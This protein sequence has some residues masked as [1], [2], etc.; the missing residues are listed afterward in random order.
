M[1]L[2]TLD[3][4]LARLSILLRLNAPVTPSPVATTPVTCRS[5][6]LDASCPDLYCTLASMSGGKCAFGVA[7]LQNGFVVCGK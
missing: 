5:P 2:V 4:V 1:A 7:R 3:G 6:G